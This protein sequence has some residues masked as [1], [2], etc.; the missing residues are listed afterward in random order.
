MTKP[1][2]SFVI[3]TMHREIELE[4]C[5]ASF[6]QD[7]ADDF[8]I[9]IVDQNADDRAL[10]IVERFRDRLRLVHLRR[11]V[12]GA[13]S[14]RNTG[15]EAAQGE[16]IGFPDDDATLRPDTLQ[17][18]RA[19]I[20]SGRYD[21]ITGMTRDEAGA[22]SVLPWSITECDITKRHLR[23][24]VAESTLFIRRDLFVRCKGF[25]P[26]FGPGG[27]FA[28][29]E[30]IDLIR[31]IRRDHP[32]ANMR[33]LPQVCLVHA[34][35]LPYQNEESLRKARSYARGR[36]ACFA[37]HWRF[38][39]KRRVLSE[40]GRHAIGSVVLRGMR[41]RS[42]VDCLLGYIDG[43]RAYRKWERTAAVVSPQLSQPSMSG[44]WN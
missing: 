35:S 44:S 2:F 33:F 26:L 32:T 17:Q 16:W 14:A 3:A 34:N 20:H 9:V 30:A 13:S 7:T 22:P 39:S 41:R 25:D 36:G 4:R 11:S 5:L 29:E 18:L 27:L 42:R 1:F 43:Y 40:V 19:H 15:A 6:L 38:V 8:E 21:L 31:R 10:R 23:S 24:T 37:R 12:A 28:A